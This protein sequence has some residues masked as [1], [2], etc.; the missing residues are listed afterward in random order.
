MKNSTEICENVVSGGHYEKREK[1][2]NLEKIDLK[3]DEKYTIG[4]FT[5]VQIGDYV[6]W[7]PSLYGV[8]VSEWA[9][10]TA[11][12]NTDLVLYYPLNETSGTT[13]EDV[14][15]SYDGTTTGATV[16]QAGKVGTSYS[17]DGAGD[18]IDTNLAEIYDDYSLGAW[19][20]PNSL[21]AS[22][23]GAIIWEIGRAHV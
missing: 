21:P 3:K 19:I 10:W 4:I 23:V 9:T 22:D 7:I 17:F 15:G 13:A 11:D 18:W 2:I 6:E 12:I 1:W 20:Y 8:R 5:D 14:H 16:N